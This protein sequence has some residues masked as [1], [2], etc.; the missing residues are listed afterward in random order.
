MWGQQELVEVLEA[1]AC[2]LH[3]LTAQGKVV[4]SVGL[5]D[6]VNK[7]SNFLNSQDQAAMPRAL[8]SVLH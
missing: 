4:Y 2:M 3:H 1:A 6:A 7:A 8:V 5:C